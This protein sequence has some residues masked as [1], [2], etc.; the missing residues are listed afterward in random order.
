[1]DSKTLTINGDAIA[2]HL[3]GESGTPI[4]FVHGNSSSSN[5]F[6][7]ILNGSLKDKYR[8][9]AIDLPGHGGSAR[10]SDPATYSL[11]GYANVVAAVA[12]ALDASEGVFVGWSLGG[13]IILEGAE[14]LADAAGFVIFGTPPV[15]SAAAMGEAFMPNPTNAILFEPSLTDEQ[16]QQFADGSFRPGES[17]PPEFVADI[18]NTDGQARA[19]MGGSIV[20]GSFTDEVAIVENLT[21]PLAIIHGEEEQLINLDY[22]KKLNIPTLWRGE[23]QVIK[24]TGHV[25]QWDTPD[26]LS[27]LIDAFVQD[28][29]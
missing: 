18:R 6:S 1:M 9:I 12:E 15:A 26:E 27:A 5:A 8:L 13:H 20:A 4:V 29:S 3:S 22:I 16:C 25:P 2:V 10:A 28:V 21:R 14:K 23:V 19:N 7:K 24:N 11:P 17:A